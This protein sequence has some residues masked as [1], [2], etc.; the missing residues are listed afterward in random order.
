MS[1]TEL[2]KRLRTATKEVS[3]ANE[4]AAEPKKRESVKA[5]LADKLKAVDEAKKEAPVKAPTKNRT[6]GID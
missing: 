6:V 1:S 2:I 3:R 4:K 5:K